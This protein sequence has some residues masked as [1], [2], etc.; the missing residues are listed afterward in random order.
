V[1][2]RVADY[3]RDRQRRGDTRQLEL[4]VQDAGG[5][6][7][8]FTQKT[9]GISWDFMGDSAKKHRDFMGFHGISIDFYSV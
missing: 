9:W 4:R 3:Q 6:K 1:F 2:E 8:D 5:K 7:G